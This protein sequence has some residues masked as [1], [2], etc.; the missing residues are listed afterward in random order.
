MGKPKASQK[1]DLGSL[2]TDSVT[3]RDL[4]GDATDEAPPQA[5]ADKPLP[6][7]CP[8][9]ARLPR[10]AGAGQGRLPAA[11]AAARPGRASRSLPGLQCR[12]LTPP[13]QAPR[14]PTGT[15]RRTAAR[16]N[17]ARRCLGWRQGRS[18]ERRSCSTGTAQAAVEEDQREPRR[19]VTRQPHHSPLLR[20]RGDPAPRRSRRRR[21]G[22]SVASVRHF[23]SE[24]E[25]AATTT[26]RKKLPR[27][28]GRRAAPPPRPTPTAA[29]LQRAGAAL[30]LRMR[31]GA[32]RL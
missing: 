8:R 17:A 32:Q 14:R 30:S 13:Q 1:T 27:P 26:A 9:R 19:R 24:K 25:A 2:P 10:G 7:G 21:S 28:P 5:A 23:E 18:A 29:R 11:E 31:G 12:C 22:P 15:Q 20:L 16:P 3:T 6:R 4:G